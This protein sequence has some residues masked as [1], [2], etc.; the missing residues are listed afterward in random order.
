M[1]QPFMLIASIAAI[2]LAVADPVSGAERQSPAEPV[3]ALK[4][5]EWLAGNW[6]GE[7][8]IELSP[9]Q[10]RSFTQTEVV[11]TKAGGTILT[12]EGQGITKAGGT[13]ATV[14]DAFTV[15]SFNPKENRYRWYSHTDKGYATDV[16]LKVDDKTFQWS[17]EAGSFGTMRYT[18]TLNN[19]GEWFE[20]GEVSRDG[21][22]WRKFFEMTLHRS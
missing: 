21:Q 18:M 19:K 15:V 1:K 10:R 11:Q 13:N 9:G 20:I 16:E 3:A 4:K 17:V 14:L 12:I 7:G 6:T 8:W 5:L 22:P 2:I